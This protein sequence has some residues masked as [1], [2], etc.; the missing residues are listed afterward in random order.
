MAA[1]GDSGASAG[2][3]AYGTTAR[4]LHWLMAVLVVIQVTAGLIMLYAAP[5]SLLGRLAEAL[6]LYSLHKVLGLVLL[7][8]VVIRIGWRIARGAPPE[9][10][11]LT[12]WQREVSTL[13]HSWIYL[14]L[15]VIPILGWVGIS[16]YP[17]LEVF[18][19]SIPALTAPDEA[20]SVAVF[21]A[22]AIAAFALVALVAMHVGAALYHHFIRG[23]GVLVRMLPG[24]QATR[25]N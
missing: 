9:E 11:T 7:G 5:P 19:F 15:I 2:V 13:V 6:G 10:P 4:V 25:R 22:H 23:D 3:Q 16:L 21:A 17:A 24:L 1:Q 14:A 8:L 18:G 12:V 20:R